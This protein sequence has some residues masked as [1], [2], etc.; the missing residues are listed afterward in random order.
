MPLADE[1]RAKLEPLPGV[2]LAVLF[3]SQAAGRAARGSDVDVGV[4]LEPDT[5]EARDRL[6]DAL[7]DAARRWVDLVDLRTAPPLLRM[8]IARHGKVL[9]ERVP[10]S[11]SDFKARAM[12]DWGDW[13]PSARRLAEAAVRRNRERLGRGQA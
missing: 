9:V 3:G 7:M 12:I 5:K 8:E 11:W 1:L 13:A 4:W 6:R 2:S 10:H